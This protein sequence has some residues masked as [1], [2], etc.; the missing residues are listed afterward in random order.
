[1]RF[2]IALLL[3]ALPHSAD[4]YVSGFFDSSVQ[5]FA[6]PRSAAPGA[7]AGTFAKPVARRPWGLAFGPDGAL[8]VA[9]EQGAPAIVRISGPFTATPGVV[10]TIVDDGAFYDLAFGPDGNLYAA[11][12]GPVRRYDVVTHQLIDEF[13]HGYALAQTRGIAF[14]P[15]GDLYVSNYEAGVKGEI[16][17]FDGITGDF[18]GVAVA[19]G[20]GGLRAPWKIAFNGRGEL[21]VANW[22]SGD[23]NIL[24]YPA[25]LHR[26]QTTAAFITRAGLEPLYLAVG[27]DRNVYVSTSDN[28]GASGAVLRFDGRSGAFIDVFVPAVAGGPRGLAFAPG[29][30]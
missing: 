29:A 20:Y 15:D 14:G 21:L 26:G 22:E 10:E 8:W 3:A 9:N 11:G 4:L 13:T 24:R 27:P 30:R 5:R 17:R 23:G 18:L 12:A 7:A 1:M 6:G 28:S 2:L 19:N 16:V 25:R